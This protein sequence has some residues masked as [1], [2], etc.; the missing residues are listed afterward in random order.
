ME[1]PLLDDSKAEVPY[2]SEIPPAWKI[3]GSGTQAGRLLARLYGVTPV[4]KSLINYPKLN[5]NNKPGPTDAIEQSRPHWRAVNAKS[6]S[7]DPRE[8]HFDKAKVTKLRVPKVGQKK[9]AARAHQS[10]VESIP[11]RKTRSACKLEVDKNSVLTAAYRPPSDNAYA[12]TKEKDRLVE[13]FTHKGGCALPNELTLPIS[14]APSEIQWRMKENQR[15]HKVLAKRRG[16]I[17]PFHEQENALISGSSGITQDEFFRDLVQEV[18]ERREFQISLEET[19]LE[20]ETV[21]IISAEISS[22]I[23]ELKKIDPKRTRQLIIDLYGKDT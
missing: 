20:K 16:A 4:N 22:R 5:R 15:V 9:T 3:F 10:E 2:N 19:G 21:Q 7:S 12:T 14:D 11:R 6:G 13:I 8:P 1:H 17:D 23:R 18:K